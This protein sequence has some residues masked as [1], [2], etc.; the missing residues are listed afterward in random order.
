MHGKWVQSLGAGLCTKGLD[1][2]TILELSQALG[3]VTQDDSI[4]EHAKEV[5]TKMNQEDGNATAVEIVSAYLD[6]LEQNCDCNNY[7]GIQLKQQSCV[8]F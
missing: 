3:K 5:G 6:K 1:K 4:R 8:R 2:V 7:L